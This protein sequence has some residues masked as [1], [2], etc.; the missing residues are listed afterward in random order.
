MY[1][2]FSCSHASADGMLSTQHNSKTKKNVRSLRSE[3]S[4]VSDFSLVH[5][6]GYY[7]QIPL[8]LLRFSIHHVKLFSEIACISHRPKWLSTWAAFVFH[9]RKSCTFLLQC[10]QDMQFPNNT[11]LKMLIASF[12]YTVRFTVYSLLKFPLNR[13]GKKYYLRYK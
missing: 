11:S 9:L 12:S 10:I 1:V 6:L 2:K 5:V 4:E 8:N 7:F 13:S 3:I